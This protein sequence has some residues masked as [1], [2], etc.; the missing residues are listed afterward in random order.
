MPAGSLTAVLPPHT[1]LTLHQPRLGRH[2]LA[3]L[4]LLLLRLLLFLGLLLLLLL[5]SSLSRVRPSNHTTHGPYA[6]AAAAVVVV[7]GCGQWVGHAVNGWCGQHASQQA[8]LH[9]AVKWGTEA[10]AI[11]LRLLLLTFTTA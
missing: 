2:Q 10:A 7:V 9:V 3:R 5:S 11:C 4:L 8:P 1:L 6:A